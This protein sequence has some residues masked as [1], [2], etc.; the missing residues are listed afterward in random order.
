MR[1]SELPP[2]LRVRQSLSST[3]GRS[4]AERLPTGYQRLGRVLILRLPEELRPHFRAIG[5]SWCAEMGVEAVLRQ[6]GPTVGELRVPRLELI[7]GED[8]RTEVVE[9]GI[10]YRLDAQQIL[11]ARGNRAER[12]RAGTETRPGEVVADLFAGIGYFALPAAVTG[13]AGR[14]WAIEKNP[15]SFAYLTENARRNHVDDRMECLRGDNRE[16]GLPVGTFDR[17][18]LGYL[19]SSLPWIPLAVRLLKPRGGTVH[20]HLVTDHRGGSSKAKA[21]VCDAAERAG[22]EVLEAAPRA[23][24]AFGPGRDHYA[25]DL[26]VRPHSEPTG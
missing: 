25:V 1:R 26:R 23:V 4:V 10:R 8:A 16:V 22:A 2:A 11:F 18:F 6:S 14:V 7:A 9:Y 19:P 15:L 20:V 21:A 3:L 5:A 13:R 12:H 17:V 24:K